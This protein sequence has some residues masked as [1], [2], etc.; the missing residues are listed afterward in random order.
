MFQFLQG[1]R[2]YEGYKGRAVQLDASSS[3]IQLPS[4]LL[5]ELSDFTIAVWVYLDTVSTWARVFDFG[6]G[7]RRY[8]FLTARG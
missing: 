8:M 7:S 1:E 3:F 4:G 2:K 5:D 6:S